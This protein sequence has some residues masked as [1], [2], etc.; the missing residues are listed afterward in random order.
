MMMVPLCVGNEIKGTVVHYVVKTIILLLDK[1]Q[2]GYKAYFF[3]ALVW[4]M[5]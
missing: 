5:L 3:G 2:A 4:T 1:D